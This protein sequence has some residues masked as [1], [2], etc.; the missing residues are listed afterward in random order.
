MSGETPKA[1]KA[2]SPKPRRL[3][4]IVSRKLGIET[5]SEMVRLSQ[6]ELIPK[7]KKAKEPIARTKAKTPIKKKKTKTKIATTRASGIARGAARIDRIA[8]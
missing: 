4:P 6:I 7:T 3:I 1:Q 8:I 2:D 5:P